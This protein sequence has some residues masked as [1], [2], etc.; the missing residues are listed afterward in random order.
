MIVATSTAYWAALVP[1]PEQR[2][3][4]APVSSPGP[5]PA[6]RRP[7]LLTVYDCIGGSF[8][9]ERARAGGGGVAIG[10]SMVIRCSCFSCGKGVVAHDYLSARRATPTWLR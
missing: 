3:L 1:Q 10:Q 6:R 8:L 9:F 5:R 7:L 2:T 4:A